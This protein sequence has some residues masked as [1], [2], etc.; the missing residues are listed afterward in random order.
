MNTEVSKEEINCFDCGSVK[1]TTFAPKGLPAYRKIG[2]I[3]RC[4][5]DLKNT[6]DVK[7]DFY[8]R[9]RHKDCP[10]VVSDEVVTYECSECKA[11]KEA[12]EGVVVFC[13]GTI[14]VGAYCK[15]R[16]PLERKMDETDLYPKGEGS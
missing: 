4:H 13:T 3:V 2:R 9:G 11:T 1:V 10:R 16:N 15:N 5:H 6:F 7:G 14:G 12:W 8:A